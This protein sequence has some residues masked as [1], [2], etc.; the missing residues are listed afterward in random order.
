MHLSPLNK[1]EGCYKQRYIKY[2]TARCQFKWLQTDSFC[3][4]KQGAAPTSS[5]AT[6]R[7]VRGLRESVDFVAEATAAGEFAKM[8]CSSHPSQWTLVM[9][10]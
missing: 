7:D 5:C 2:T 10:R 6:G 3:R 9:W 8:L 1:S 4:S